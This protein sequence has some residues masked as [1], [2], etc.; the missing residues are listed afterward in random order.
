M[1]AL[2]SKKYFKQKKNVYSNVY[3]EGAYMLDITDF[4]FYLMENGVILLDEAGIDF[5]NRA[6]KKFD[7]KLTRF[8]K[9][10]GHY[11][12]DVYLVSQDYDIDSKIRKLAVEIFI[13]K[14]C[15]LYPY[16]FKWRSIIQKIDISDDHKEIAHTFHWRFL[17]FDFH[18]HFAFPL[19]KL[20]NSH[21]Q[22]K[23]NIKTWVTWTKENEQHMIKDYR[24][25][26]DNKSL[27]DFNSLP[28][29]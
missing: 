1:L 10:H 14:K 19:W 11:N 18:Y 27:I 12:L 4:N 6:W 20:F 8:F 15:L 24:I 26:K 7:E 9:L 16:I 21:Y 13:I 3:I 2:L 17:L 5:D 25:T 22:D 28:K 23:L 29:A